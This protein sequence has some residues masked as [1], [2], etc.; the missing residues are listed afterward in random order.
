MPPLNI[1]LDLEEKLLGDHDNTLR[2]TMIDDLL[3]LL[4]SLEAQRRLLND[5][6]RYLEIVSAVQAVSSALTILRT[7]FV[8][9]LAEP[10]K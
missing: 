9:R 8:D 3:L 5:R 7:L 6:Q 2:K 10:K 1:M 4:K